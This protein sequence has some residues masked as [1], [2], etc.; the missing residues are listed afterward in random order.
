[1]SPM[2]ESGVFHPVGVGVPC[3]LCGAPTLATWPFEQCWRCGNREWEV[4]SELGKIEQQIAELQAKRA[5]AE[6]E[7]ALVERETNV[8]NREA[9]LREVRE[10]A[11]VDDPVARATAYRERLEAETAEARARAEAARTEGGGS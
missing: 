10:P 8:A 9:E 6:R 5:E 7:A 2:L 1:M 3:P 4:V 11:E